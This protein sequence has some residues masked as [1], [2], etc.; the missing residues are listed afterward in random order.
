V[1]LGLRIGEY[2]W[3]ASPQPIAKDV[4]HAWQW[5]TIGGGSW[6]CVTSLTCKAPAMSLQ[7]FFAP[8]L[9]ALTWELAANR[10]AAAAPYRAASLP[11]TRSIILIG[12]MPP[13][14]M[15]NCRPSQPM[16]MESV[17]GK[18]YWGS[19]QLQ[20]ALT[21]KKVNMSTGEAQDY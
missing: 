14:P 19:E 15:Q 10:C 13:T 11:L 20:L 9:Q 16:V 7:Q 2:E 1:F 3:G 17:K 6:Y 5:T 21:F 18:Y 12:A 8:N 4:V